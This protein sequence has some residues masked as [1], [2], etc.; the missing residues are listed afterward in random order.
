[1]PRLQIRDRPVER[2]AAALEDAA[3]VQNI[4][5]PGAHHGRARQVAAAVHQRARRKERELSVVGALGAVMQLRGQAV[6]LA[7]VGVAAK[8]AQRVAD[9]QANQAADG[10][11]VA[12]LPMP[13]VW[14]PPSPLLSPQ[15]RA[16]S[17]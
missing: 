1:M 10:L 9:G 5:L 8:V 13:A 17:R 2:L 16:G 14:V 3:L 12:L 11:A 4:A 6:A 15:R 7:V